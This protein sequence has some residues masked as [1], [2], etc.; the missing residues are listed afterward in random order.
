M[1]PQQRNDVLRT[2]F[3]ILKTQVNTISGKFKSTM[4]QSPDEF[5]QPVLF[6]DS[7]QIM[8]RWTAG[9][10][11]SGAPQTAKIGGQEYPINPDGTI[12]VNG[13][14]Y[15]LGSDGRTLNLVA[16]NTGGTNGTF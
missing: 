15:K 2:Q 7:Q 16:P 13:H 3:G 10:I 6:G 9:N 14:N 8:D 1:T 12:V 4:G 5:G 11:G